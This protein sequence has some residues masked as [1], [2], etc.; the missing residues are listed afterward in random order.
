MKIKEDFVTNS[1]STS[2]V[3]RAKISGMIPSIIEKK[4]VFTINKPKLAEKIKSMFPEYNLEFP[5]EYAST[6][7]VIEN[8]EKNEVFDGNSR[9]GFHTTEYYHEKS[10]TVDPIII[11]HG[12]ITGPPITDSDQD[13]VFDEAVHMIKQLLKYVADGLYKFTYT[14]F[15]DEMDSGGW[16][17]GDPMGDYAYTFD[18]IEHES[19]VGVI[20]VLKENNQFKFDG[21]IIHRFWGGSKVFKEIDDEGQD[22]DSK[23]VI[24]KTM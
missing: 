6:Y 5:F 9:I 15:P 24:N 2:F 20:E 21:P 1:S 12:A 4:D 23:L 16:D 8:T 7:F 10:D 19:C 14:Q 3:L 13:I 17:G 18:C 11:T 22:T